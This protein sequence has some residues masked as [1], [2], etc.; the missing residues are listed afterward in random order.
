MV[1]GADLHQE[2]QLLTDLKSPI[3]P[4]EILLYLR[5]DLLNSSWFLMPL[6]NATLLQN[7]SRKYQWVLL[8]LV[9][10]TKVYLIHDVRMEEVHQ[11]MIPVEYSDVL[12]CDFQALQLL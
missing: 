2:K 11:P 9:V 10:V 3:I 4:E 6:G 5:V 7:C 12:G 8:L 1:V